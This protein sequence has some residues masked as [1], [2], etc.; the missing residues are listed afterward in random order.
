MSQDNPASAAPRLFQPITLNGLSLTNRIVVAPMCQYS[1]VNGCAG[2]WHRMHVGMLTSNGAGLVILEATAVTEDGRITPGCLGIWGDEQAQALG[3]LID[4][5]R[6]FSTGAIGI[7]LAHAGRKGSSQAPFDGP[8]RL[9]ADQGGWDTL[10]PSPIPA[11]PSDTVLPIEMT[12][13]DMDQ[14]RDAFVQACQRSIE[15]GVSLIELH[16]AHGYLLHQFLSPL[17]N[18]RTDDYGGSL[19]NRMRFPLEV[20]NAMRQA[21]PADY[22][23]GVRVSAT[24]WVD[25]GWD[26][27]QTEK[28]CQQLQALG[29]DFF[30]ISSGG[31]SSAQK[32]TLTPGYQVPLAARLKQSLTVPVMAVGL[33]T[34]PSHAEQILAE[35]SADMVAL[36]RQILLDP[37]WPWRAAQE[38]GGKVHV[39]KQY[40]R[41]LPASVAY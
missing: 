20:F 2:D 6:A 25:G 18:Q 24:D 9:S 14:V 12:R 34:E 28:L 3:A 39:P 29:C 33:I 30:D 11:R 17:S 35:G 15:A 38:L 10:A 4:A 31:V 23:L 8:A 40:L 37:H 1:A 27:D 36:A 22:P 7:Q 19:D 5:S 32:I 41:S 26:V 21:V 13:S 16:M